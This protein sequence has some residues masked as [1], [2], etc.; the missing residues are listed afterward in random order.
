MV[1]GK[2]ADYDAIGQLYPSGT[3]HTASRRSQAGNRYFAK[4]Y[5]SIFPR[6]PSSGPYYTIFA[7]HD[8]AR[9]SERY[10]VSILDM[11]DQNVGVVTSAARESLSSPSCAEHLASMER[12]KRTIAQAYKS[13]LV[14][15]GEQIH[16]CRSRCYLS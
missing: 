15:G 3:M 13:H 11:L 9:R 2:R 16:A 6:D 5:A 8:Y 1:S 14:L 4:D 12:E 10:V 7:S